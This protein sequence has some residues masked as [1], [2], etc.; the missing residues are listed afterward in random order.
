MALALSMAI[1]A[2]SHGFRWYHAEYVCEGTVI[3]RDGKLET[4]G[5]PVSVNNEL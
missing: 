2:V 3:W 4:S 1:L 5:G